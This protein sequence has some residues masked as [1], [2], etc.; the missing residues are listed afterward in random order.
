MIVTTRVS[1]QD[2]PNFVITL[3]LEEMTIMDKYFVQ[4]VF[5][6]LEVE[7]QRSVKLSCEL[8][9]I[10]MIE[11]VDCVVFT[12]GELSALQQSGALWFV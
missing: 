4:N 7:S 12:R 6:C 3:K 11:Q 5:P 8:S 9:S 2:C 1:L 10:S